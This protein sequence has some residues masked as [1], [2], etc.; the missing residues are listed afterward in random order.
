MDPEKIEDVVEQPEATESDDDELIAAISEELNAVSE[1]PEE[2]DDS[3]PDNEGVSAESEVDRTETEDVDTAEPV[4]DEAKPESENDTGVGDGAE[5]EEVAAEATPE[6]TEGEESEP[7]AE[8]PSDEFGTLDQDTSEKTRDRFEKLKSSYDAVVQERDSIR[9]E[10]EKFGEMVRNTGT[11]PE[12]FSNMLTYLTKVNS[13]KREDLEE[14]FQFLSQETNNIARALGQAAPGGYNPLNEHGD[15]KQRVDEGLLSE[16]DAMEIAQAR[17][18]KA[19]QTEQDNRASETA[20]HEQQVQKALDEVRELGATL[21]ANDPQFQAKIPYLE[22][23]IASAVTSGAKP[24][25]WKQ[26]IEEAY[27]K[28]PDLPKAAAPT[29]PKAPPSPDPIRPTGATPSSGSMDKEPGSAVE[30]LD[31]ALARG[32]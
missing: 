28:L 19:W 24:E 23:I 20:A 27:K 18:A 12:Q 25:R 2:S 5:G 8:K 26:M 30:A 22:P 4:A 14:A 16:S 13:G 3:E 9:N 15:L 32:W 1:V 7:V 17:A 31:Q 11:G 10:A 29:P 6:A 21:S